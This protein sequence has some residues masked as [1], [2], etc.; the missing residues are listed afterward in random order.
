M[1]GL[2]PTA[3]R[4]RND[5]KDQL[6][7]CKVASCQMQRTRHW[8]PMWLLQLL[9]TSLESEQSDLEAHPNGGEIFTKSEAT[10]DAAGDGG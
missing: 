6:L 8:L 1:P 2:A 4:S 10:G 3:E 9:D 7:K 5:L